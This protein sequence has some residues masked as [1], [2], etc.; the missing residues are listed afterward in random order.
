MAHLDHKKETHTASSN[1]LN[2]SPSED[3][4]HVSHI[5]GL[6]SQAHQQLEALEVKNCKQY[7]AKVNVVVKLG[8]LQERELLELRRAFE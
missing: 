2:N 4:F 6:I 3:I 7:E 5:E 1:G 8:R